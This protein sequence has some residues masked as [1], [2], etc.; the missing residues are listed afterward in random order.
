ME[1]LIKKDIDDVTMR[2]QRMFMFLLK[3]P[4]MNITYRP[5]K[6]ML[7]DADC[8]SRA[9]LSEE[10]ELE[11]LSGVIHRIMELVCLS[12]ENFKYYRNILDGDEKYSRICR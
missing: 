9:Q 7:V 11:G 12:E 4:G 10:E 1:T 3:Y 2:L 6:E 5:G 8:L